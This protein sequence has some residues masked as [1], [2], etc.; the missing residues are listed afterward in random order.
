MTIST[1]E[2]ENV[3]VSLEVYDRWYHEG[4]F[5]QILK[6]LDVFCR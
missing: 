5:N 1:E 3:I 4:S 6:L 2:N